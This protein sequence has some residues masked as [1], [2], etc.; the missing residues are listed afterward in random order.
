[1]DDL[2]NT[3]WLF[4]TTITSLPMTF[5]LTFS[6]GDGISLTELEVV[7]P[8]LNQTTINYSD[9]EQIIV[10]YMNT[11]WTNESYRKIH[12]TGGADVT[13]PLLINF[14]QQNAVRLGGKISKIQVPDGTLYDIGGESSSYTAGSG[15]DITNDVISADTTVVATQNDLSGKVS[16]TGDTMTG[17]LAINNNQ[18]LKMNTDADFSKTPSSNYY[19]SG[20][21]FFDSNNAQY[22]VA[23]ITN[24]TN[25]NK[26]FNIGGQRIINNTTYY[27][28]LR[29]L[30]DSSGKAVVVLQGTD[31]PASWRTAIGAQ[32]TLTAGNGIVI[33]GNTI[34]NRF[35]NLTNVDLNTIR[36]NCQAYAGDSCTNKPTTNGGMFICTM[37]S[38]DGTYGAQLFI[39][40]ATTN[41]GVY[42]RRFNGSAT[43]TEWVKLITTEGGSVETLTTTGAMIAQSL[44]IKSGSNQTSPPFFLCL[45]NSFSAGGNV[46]YVTK[47]NMLSAING[48]YEKNDT[49]TI[50]GN[51]QIFACYIYAP[52]NYNNVRFFIPTDKPI[53]A[54]TVTCTKLTITLQTA[55]N[56][57]GAFLINNAN[58][59]G[60]S[61]Y[62]IT[63][64]ARGSGIYVDLK[65][66]TTI[67]LTNRDTGT[68]ILGSSKFTFS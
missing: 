42:Y 14:L 52:T 47:T 54:S 49:F 25:G 12:I 50:S 68:V 27:N 21:R 32:A 20:V 22:G 9:G 10:A 38:N 8:V 58:V 2:T 18:Q 11:T 48:T 63:C 13:K 33:S 41:Q 23:Q 66:P 37:G 55:K 6:S 65:C 36:Y 24:L 61:G 44:Q 7:A 51:Y 35:T 5:N 19:S 26:G 39:T 31:A 28:G 43:P 29:L 40:Y 59:Y 64:T 34:I 17:A 15:I 3:T 62:T 45:N 60:V 4:N 67:S 30:V 46:G 57:Q 1:M 56:A 53:T 16:K